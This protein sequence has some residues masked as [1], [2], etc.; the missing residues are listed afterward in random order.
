MTNLTSDEPLGEIEIPPINSHILKRST[1][2]TNENGE[3]AQKESIIEIKE[4]EHNQANNNK[5][6]NEMQ[7]LINEMLDD[8]I[9]EGVLD[10]PSRFVEEKIEKEEPPKKEEKKIQKKPP[11]EI[12]V[13]VEIKQIKKTTNKKTSTPQETPEEQ[14]KRLI[15]EFLNELNEGYEVGILQLS[16]AQNSGSSSKASHRK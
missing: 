2:I 11:K 5:E 3:T 1:R 15:H 8:D 13:P 9:V 12:Q 6:E 7:K 14:E 4:N 16:D 10:P